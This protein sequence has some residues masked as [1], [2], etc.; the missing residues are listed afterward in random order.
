MESVKNNKIYDNCLILKKNG[1]EFAFVSRRIAELYVKNNLAVIEDCSNDN[2]IIKLIKNIDNFEINEDDD[3]EVVKKENKCVVCLSE[4]NLTRHHIVPLCFV[5]H[6][7]NEFR[8]YPTSNRNSN[9]VALCLKCHK[10]YEEY[11]DKIK[12]QMFNEIDNLITRDIKSEID[13]LK[14]FLNFIGPVDN[15]YEYALRM[16]KVEILDKI[17]Q[18]EN[19]RKSILNKF[20]ESIENKFKIVIENKKLDN[21]KA[22][23]EFSK[24]WYTHFINKMRPKLFKLPEN[25]KR[26]QKKKG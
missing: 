12:E 2:F 21:E 20:N 23:F 18:L 6:F 17:K 9:I 10:K 16:S 13:Y 19:K 1:K 3:R 24:I 8:R 5:R 11:A 7:P 22:I 25:L 26:R 4:K 14:D 15:K